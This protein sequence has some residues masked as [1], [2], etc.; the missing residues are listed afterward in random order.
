MKLPVNYEFVQNL[1]RCLAADI[2]EQYKPEEIIAISRGG[3][4][5]AHIIA[6]ELS[7]PCGFYDPKTDVLVHQTNNICFIEDLIAKGRT[8]YK[9]AKL[10]ATSDIVWSFVPLLL[11]HNA[12][13]ECQVYG[14][15]SKHWIVWPWEDCT[16]AKEGDHGLFR[17]QTDSY[18]RV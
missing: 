17:D 12:D 14:L 2:R 16:R 18:Q 5:A 3:F 13:F 7:L 6:R 4:S 10:M 1:C 9:V 8:Y 15:R 11:D